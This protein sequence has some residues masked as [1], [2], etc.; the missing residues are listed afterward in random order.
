MA[1]EEK[2]KV[3]EP[4]EDAALKEAMT[5]FGEVLLPFFGIRERVT[6]ILP[7]EEIRLEMQRLYEDFNY[8]T[9]DGKILHFEFQSKN[10]GLAGL[11]RFR[12]YEAV[13]SRKY[14]K[15]VV[16]YVLYS[17][18]IKNPMTEFTEGVNTYRVIPIIMTEKNAD[19][20]IQKV[21][22]KEKLLKEDL[23]SLLLTPLMSGTITIVERVKTS[24][25][26]MQREEKMLEQDERQKMEAVLYALASKFLDR[27]ELSEVK[28]VIRM[29]ELGR[30]LKE[31]GKAEGKSLDI[32]ELLEEYGEIP[33]NLQELIMS[34][35]DSAI[36]SKWHKL[37]AKVES[38]EE[39]TRKM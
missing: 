39:F 23:I 3:P 6:V 36:L 11:K 8:G 9:E 34:Q 20:I 1:Y 38:I 19:A 5:Y 12:V 2:R 17:G 26:I 7:T 25:S 21:E 13:T 15:E 4:R 33:G 28:E 14:K 16:T 35:K 22:R 27:Q 10:E 30:M 29:T 31:E 24:F 32:L 37:A 18:K